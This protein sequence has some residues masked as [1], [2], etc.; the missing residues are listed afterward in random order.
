VRTASMSS[1][2]KTGVVC[3]PVGGAKATLNVAA[4]VKMNRDM[5]SSLPRCVKHR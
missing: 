4:T 1:A 2:V 5:K 3:A